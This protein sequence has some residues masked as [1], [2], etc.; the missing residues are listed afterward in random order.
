MRSYSVVTLSYRNPKRCSLTLI[1]F[2]SIQGLRVIG[3]NFLYMVISML[4]KTHWWREWSMI[5]Q[6]E[7]NLH[8]HYFWRK[9][10]G[11]TNE[12]LSFNPFTARVFDRVLWGNSHFWVCRRN[13]MMWPF[14]WKLS[15]CTFTRCYLFVKILEN[16]IWKFGLNFPLTTFDSER[17][18]G[19]I[20]LLLWWE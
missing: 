2:Y 9:L 5:K 18:K 17:A 7:S 11:T 4:Y 6:F 12:H 14:K 15:A 1:G 13:P 8:L 16:D 10:M 3:V 20:H 19:E